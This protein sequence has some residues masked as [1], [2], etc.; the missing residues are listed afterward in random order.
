MEDTGHSSLSFIIDGEL[1]EKFNLELRAACH[2]CTHHHTTTP[3]EAAKQLERGEGW[4]RDWISRKV[5]NSTRQFGGL[6]ICP[7][8]DCPGHSNPKGERRRRWFCRFCINRHLGV[9]LKNFF[10]FDEAQGKWFQ[11]KPT[12]FRK[13][14]NPRSPPPLTTQQASSPERER[15]GDREKRK[16]QR[17]REEAWLNVF[18][19]LRSSWT[20]LELVCQF[21][22]SLMGADTRSYMLALPG[23]SWRCRVCELSSEAYKEGQ[24]AKR[25]ASSCHTIARYQFAS[26]CQFVGNRR[27]CRWW[28]R[29]RGFKRGQRW[30][31]RRYW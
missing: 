6:F 27:S 1:W 31:S 15:E 11:V 9:D 24:E 26:S 28:L 19:K 3:A 12:L 2:W 21:F 16:R 10:Q 5:K 30:W 4:P 20:L 23:P 17:Q 14:W 22:F 7:A 8:S 25:C 29:R 13:P 18:L